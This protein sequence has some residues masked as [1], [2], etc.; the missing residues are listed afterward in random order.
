MGGE[1]VSDLR[2]L[3]ERYVVLEAE[4]ETVRRAMVSALTNGAGGASLLRPTARLRPALKEP[5][6]AIFGAAKDADAKV[7]ELLKATPGMTGA[8]IMRATNSKPTTLQQRL[9]RLE[10][11]SLV[12]RDDSGAWSAMTAS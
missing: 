3:A 11:R 2:A 8:A 12:R 6:E 7:L 9:K 5:R 10:R 1:A 4:I